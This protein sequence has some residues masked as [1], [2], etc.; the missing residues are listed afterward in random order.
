MIPYLLLAVLTAVGLGF[1][2]AILNV[3]YRDIR[4]ALP[5]FIQLLLFVTPVIYPLARVP[6]RWHW[7]MFLNP[8][9][10]VIEGVRAM[11]FHTS[12]L[13]GRGLLISCA[14]CSVMVVLGIWCY[15]KY[16]QQ[17]ADII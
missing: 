3:K 9:T 4:Y 11:L 12:P 10:S 2:L 8:L 14:S 7:L 1:M 13:D 15:Q 17:I 6:P 5:F 16:E